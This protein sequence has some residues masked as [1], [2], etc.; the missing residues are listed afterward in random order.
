MT[1][2]LSWVPLRCTSLSTVC[3][4]TSA[5]DSAHVAQS[6]HRIA[7]LTPKYPARTW[8]PQLFSLVVRTPWHLPPKVV[9]LAHLFR[10]PVPVGLAPWKEVYTGRNCST[11]STHCTLVYC[12]VPRVLSFLQ[13]QWKVSSTLKVYVVAILGCCLAPTMTYHSTR[14]VSSSWALFR[15][16]LLKEVKADATSVSLQFLQVLHGLHCPSQWCV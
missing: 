5:T 8:F 14:I 2:S 11:N 6:D 9:L 4:S 1:A 12:P 16:M 15:G 10:I 3:I 13:G 7:L